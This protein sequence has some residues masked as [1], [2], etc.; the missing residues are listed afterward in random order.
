[1][2]N[3]IIFTADDR[4][5]TER[6]TARMFEFTAFLNNLSSRRKAHTVTPWTSEDKHETGFIVWYN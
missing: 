6:N 3:F 2:K 4:E 1:M 5:S